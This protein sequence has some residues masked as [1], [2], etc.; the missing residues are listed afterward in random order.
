MSKKPSLE[1]GDDRSR[2]AIAH[3]LKAVEAAVHVIGGKWK[4][5]ILLH[6]HAAGTCRFSELCRR[7]PLI[8]PQSLTVQLRELERDGIVHREIFAEVP[9]RVEYSLSALGTNISPMMTPLMT[10]GYAILEQRAQA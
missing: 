10:W 4:I 7:M 6:L 1:R 5:M 3:D 9:P 8:T 2:Q